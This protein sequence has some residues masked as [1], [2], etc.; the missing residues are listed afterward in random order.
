M[1]PGSA[2]SKSIACHNKIVKYA[3][4]VIGKTRLDH[5]RVE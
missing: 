5:I 3:Y 4:P 1:E 2:P